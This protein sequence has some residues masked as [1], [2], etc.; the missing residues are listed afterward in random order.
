MSPTA[1]VSA[2]FTRFAQLLRC[3]SYL[4]K[5]QRSDWLNGRQECAGS[6]ISDTRLRFASPQSDEFRVPSEGRIVVENCG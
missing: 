5:M 1:F 4:V 2:C 3:A 6:A